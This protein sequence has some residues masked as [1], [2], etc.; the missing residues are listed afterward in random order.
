MSDED[1]AEK[2]E[3]PTGK[4][5]ADSKK[6]GEF[7]KSKEF[8][9]FTVLFVG[10]GGML[11]LAPEKALSHKTFSIT[12]FRWVPQVMDD[13]RL[14]SV[15]AVSSAIWHLW[16]FLIL[17]LF[18]LW[19]AAVFFGMINQRFI[20]PEDALKFDIKK[21]NPIT[22]FK[23]KFMSLQPIVELV[24][25]VL[26]LFLLGY[27]VWAIISSQWATLPTLIHTHPSEVL[28]LIH[29]LVSRIFWGCMPLI[30][31]IVVFDFAYQAY[32]TNK[33]Q[34]MSHKEIKDE[35]KEAEGSPELK[36]KQRQK[37]REFALG[38]IMREVP[39]ADVIIVNPTHYSVAIR[40][41]KEEADAPKVV[42]KGV[43]FLA[44]KIRTIAGQYDIP[45]VEN[46]SLARGLYAQTKK[47]QEIHPDFYTAVAEILAMIYRRRNVNKSV[48][49]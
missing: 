48:P 14:A 13:P 28:A 1:D 43:D 10:F 2:T 47:G 5:L 39:K 46:P 23:E 40:Y 37:Q 27:V 42:A 9:A 6:K 26:K 22:G 29:I 7:A 18:M 32:D 12:I 15:H 17:P 25:S 16:D 44:M 4:K 36:A 20:I 38:G 49:M 24:K 21:L 30:I 35:R 8:M 19:V 41:Q 31:V 33:K 11:L 45:I 34:K 3:D